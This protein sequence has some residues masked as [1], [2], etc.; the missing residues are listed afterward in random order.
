MH[1]IYPRVYESGWSLAFNANTPSKQQAKYL[2][3]QLMGSGH[4]KPV[5]LFRS[6]FGVL[7]QICWIFLHVKIFL[8]FCSSFVSKPMIMGELS[9][10]ITK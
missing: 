6:L 8:L 1:F 10:F 4:I 3:P 5:A 7:T 9:V 2:N